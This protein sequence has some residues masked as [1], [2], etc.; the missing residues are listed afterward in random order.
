M[1]K[2]EAIDR[3]RSLV[4]TSA[5]LPEAH[6]Q[7][8]AI[9]GILG[10]DCWN[11]RMEISIDYNDGVYWRKGR[12]DLE[13]EKEGFHVAIEIDRKSPRT[14]SILKLRAIHADLRLV[15]VREPGWMGDTPPGID[16]VICVGT[17][18]GLGKRVLSHS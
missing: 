13:A 2:Q 1:T 10:R 16:A 7:Q 18:R 8:N 6:W 12:I 3:I 9:G 15:I 4:S 5:R 17:E 11:I 14:K